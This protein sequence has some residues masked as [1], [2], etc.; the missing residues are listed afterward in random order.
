MKCPNCGSEVPRFSWSWEIICPQC[1]RRYPSLRHLFIILMLVLLLAIGNVYFVYVDK[2]H[3]VLDILALVGMWI[4][5]AIV[6]LYIAALYRKRKSPTLLAQ[7]K[8]IAK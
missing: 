1:G 6:A 3:G 4:L 8:P 5:L 7:E 2:R